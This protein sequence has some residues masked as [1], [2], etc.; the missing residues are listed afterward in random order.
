M[1][2]V[3]FNGSCVNYMLYYVHKIFKTLLYNV[4]VEILMIG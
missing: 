4:N 3:F 1:Q 2:K